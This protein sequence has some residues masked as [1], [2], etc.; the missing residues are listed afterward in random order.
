MGLAI[1]DIPFMLVPYR[2][3]NTLVFICSLTSFVSGL[4][5]SS[6]K[7]KSTPLHSVCCLCRARQFEIIILSVVFL[8][9]T[10]WLCIL[11]VLVLVR[12]CR[13]ISLMWLLPR[14]CDA[15]V[16]FLGRHYRVALCCAAGRVCRAFLFF[17][18]VQ[19]GTKLRQMALCPLSLVWTSSAPGLLMAPAGCVDLGVAQPNA[20]P[21]STRP[22]PL[23]PIAVVLRS[24]AYR[25]P[26][27]N[28]HSSSLV[29][30]KGGLLDTAS[31]P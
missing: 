22:V 18:A 27:G 10:P 30:H 15:R 29:A 3:A 14:V 12:S 31:P 19:D 4:G 7:G 21:S 1:G 9:C 11:L 25:L 23:E 2:Y 6:N 16:A 26:F 28:Y 24:S 5:D 17:P 13:C 20:V 8:P